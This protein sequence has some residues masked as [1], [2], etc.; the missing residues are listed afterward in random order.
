MAGLFPYSRCV[1]HQIILH[2]E[3]KE[4]SNSLHDKAMGKE[5]TQLWTEI[6]LYITFVDT[7]RE[8]FLGQAKYMTQ[9]RS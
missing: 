1:N 9:K 7:L 8:I 5:L 6:A 2:R 4:K 3:Q